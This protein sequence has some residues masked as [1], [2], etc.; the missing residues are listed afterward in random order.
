MRATVAEPPEIGPMPVTVRVPTTRPSVLE[1]PPR[2][3]G[4]V[5]EP[6]PER[7]GVTGR[8]VTV[9]GWPNTREGMVQF[10]SPPAQ[11]RFFFTMMSEIPG[12]RLIPAPFF[13]SQF[14]CSFGHIAHLP[15]CRH[16]ALAFAYANQQPVTQYRR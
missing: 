2:A 4:V 3:G 6:V 11:N 7:P 16:L 14:K 12:Q 15:K 1:T 8:G 5:T 9:E 10:F 13:S